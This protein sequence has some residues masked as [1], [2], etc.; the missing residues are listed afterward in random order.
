MHDNYPEAFIEKYC[1]TIKREDYI[2]IQT[3]EFSIYGRQKEYMEF[4]TWVEELEYL[5]EAHDEDTR[6][7]CLELTEVEDNR[8]VSY[9]YPE[10]FG[11]RPLYDIGY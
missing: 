3:E 10:D 8:Y 6:Y 2:V 11:I 9:G 5:T 7:G 4:M 1:I